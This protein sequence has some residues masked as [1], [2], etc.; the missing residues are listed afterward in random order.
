MQENMRNKLFILGYIILFIV[1]STLG[2]YY[3]TK[4]LLIKSDQFYFKLSKNEFFLHEKVDLSQYLNTNGKIVNISEVK[5]KVGKQVIDFIVEYD[6]NFITQNEEIEIKD[7]TAPKLIINKSVV[8]EDDINSINS[9]VKIEDD[10]SATFEYKIVSNKIILTARD[11]SNNVTRK[12]LNINKKMIPKNKNFNKQFPKIATKPI[13]NKKVYLYFKDGFDF[14]TAYDKCKKL[15][16]E[17]QGGECIPIAK[18]G[19]YIGYIFT[20]Y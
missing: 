9:W 2:I 12:Q 3:A 13:P 14:N 5:S 18:D 7:I 17:N 11:K 19:I 10:D 15:V 4:T 8:Y 6:N 1:F 16:M 20:A